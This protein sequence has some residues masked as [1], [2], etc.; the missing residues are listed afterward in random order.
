MQYRKPGL[1]HFE[2]I[3]E[4]ETLKSKNG[5]F[6]YIVTSKRREKRHVTRIETTESIIKQFIPFLYKTVKVQ[7]L[8]GCVFITEINN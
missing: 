6:V 1:R 7:F 8:K 3:G 4:V 5:E 2:I